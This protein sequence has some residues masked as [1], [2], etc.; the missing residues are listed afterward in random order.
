MK[1]NILS[2]FYILIAVVLISC[3]EDKGNESM[4]VNKVKGVYEPQL[5]YLNEALT[6]DPDDDELL[7]KRAQVFL[8][9]YRFREA[10]KDIQTAVAVRSDK[11]EYYLV[12]AQANFALG[13]YF[14]TIKA[15]EKAEN[16][17]LEDPELP[18]LQARVYWE[19]GDTSRSA[20]YL[21]RVSQIAPFH[22][23][24]SLLKGRQAAAHG[25][26]AKAVTYYLSSIRADRSY[27]DAYRD[28]IK[29]YL[30]R[31]KDDSAL[32][33][34]VQAKELR[35]DHPDFY[36]AEGRVFYRKDMKQSAILSYKYCL[37]EDSAYELAMYQ[38]GQLYY[39][40][41]NPIEAYKYLQRY[42]TFN[43]DNKEVYRTIIALLSEQNKEAM[44]IPYYERLIQLDTI[45][46]A[47]RYKLQ[48]LYNLYSS[49]SRMDTVVAAPVAR[50]MPAIADTI[51]RR[52]RV[53]DTASRTTTPIPVVVPDSAK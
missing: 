1:K 11:P 40:E 51:R 33:Y 44:T 22:S 4:P 52:S 29:I 23:G 25:D 28:L 19:T 50:A 37:R 18:V 14:E 16:I 31:G 39:R 49:S 26:T 17:G 24:I 2:I 46:I 20:I 48:K 47:L 15:T 21:N 3:R 53:R 34:C 9:L 5:N 6:D 12:L 41:G 13:N 35:L 8:N 7:Y 30:N 43:N 42:T 27:T 38:L 45:N 10:L 36:Y 32:Y